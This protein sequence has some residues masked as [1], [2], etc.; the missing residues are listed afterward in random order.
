R[1]VRQHE[2]VAM[3]GRGFAPPAAPAFIRPRAADRAEHIAPHHPRADIFEAPRGHLLVD[4][5][6]AALL[7]EDHAL[8][9][10]GREE[11][12]VQLLAPLPER[13]VEALVRPGAEPVEGEGKAVNAYPGHGG[14]PNK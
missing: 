11:P 9:G 4:A 2:D 5:V 7:V 6:R 8:D 13:I 14:L 1:M 10:A 12:F 3:I